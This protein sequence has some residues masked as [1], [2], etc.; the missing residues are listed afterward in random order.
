[1]RSRQ[2][3]AGISSIVQLP[4]TVQKEAQVSRLTE[5]R[6]RPSAKA[7][8]RRKCNAL[9]IHDS[10][11]RERLDEL[12]SPCPGTSRDSQGRECGFISPFH[13]VAAHFCGW[14]WMAESLLYP[15]L[16]LQ[17][18]ARWEFQS[19]IGRNKMWAASLFSRLAP[20]GPI[21]DI[22]RRY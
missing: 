4:Q 13:L 19:G 8:Q 6:H 11:W 16:G 20:V 1:M 22:P 2:N 10:D 9:R 5:V 15:D 17:A 12:N 7:A 3:R 14:F 18:F 21:L